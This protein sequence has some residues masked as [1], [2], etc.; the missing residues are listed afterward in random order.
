M[1]IHWI[2]LATRSGL[3]DHSRMTVLAHFGDAEDVYYA[4]D[5]A[6]AD[7]PD[8]SEAAI[9][10][11]RDKNLAEAE[12][13]AEECNLKNIQIL[14]WRDAA[15]PVR[16]KN[17][18]DPPVVLYY[19]GKL[20]DFDALPLIAVVGTR[21]ASAY[22]LGTAKRLG[23][24]IAACGGVVVSGMAY[25]V[26]GMAMRGALTAEGFV[27]GVLGCGAD[28]VYPV[29]NR[30]LFA[31]TES[32]GCLLT[33]FPPG[34]PPAKWT[35][36][37]RNRIISGLS[38]GVLVVEAPEKS[39]ALITARLAA[40]QGRDVFVV[41]GNIDVDSCRGSNALLRDGAIAVGSG[42]D[43]MSEYAALYPGKIHRVTAPSHQTAYPDEV[44]KASR[45]EP[46]LK[47]AQK[48]RLPQPKRSKRTSTR[49]KEIDNG[50]P[51]PYIDAE[52]KLPPLSADE[53]RVLSLVR[54]NVTLVDDMIHASGMEAGTV[55]TAL[56]MLEI[57]GVVPRLPGKRV[58]LKKRK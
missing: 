28:I 21:S 11:L 50:A 3:S 5:D 33:E 52:E 27:V 46:A 10:S 9:T 53:E 36:P 25:G 44:E 55:L 16:L 7:V 12:W 14:T 34:T 35:F 18:S 22:G 37:K 24:Q 57:K 20:P 6:F 13:I 47:V 8:L 41:P 19:K 40:E 43:V 51:S 4:P 26:D 49:K 29:S 54:Q 38:C 48:P 56:T 31:D 2:W 1:R 39:G 23:S 58:E 30:A 42:W 45:E 32:Q 17:I 15:Y